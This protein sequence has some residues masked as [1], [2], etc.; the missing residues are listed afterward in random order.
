M[1]DEI[2]TLTYRCAAELKRSI[3]DSVPAMEQDDAKKHYSH[4]LHRSLYC[5]QPLPAGV[6]L[7]QLFLRGGE[8]S[9]KLAGLRGVCAMKI[10][11]REQ[12]LDA[13]DLLVHSMDL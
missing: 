9:R 3:N 11:R 1:K 8:I 5:L 7:R 4:A 2:P 12:A 10:Q 6:K 13:D